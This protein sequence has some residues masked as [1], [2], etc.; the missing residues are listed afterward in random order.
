MHESMM[1]NQA[2]TL[3]QEE[4][5]QMATQGKW[6]RCQASSNPLTSS[7]YNL[8]R[9]ELH[10]CG[11]FETDKWKD[12][13]KATLKRNLRAIRVPTIM[14]LNPTCKH[15]DLNLDEYEMLDC[16]PMHDLKGHLFN[17]NKKLPYLLTRDVRKSCEDII[18]ATVSVK[19]TW[20]DRVLILQLYLHLR[21]EKSTKCILNPLETAIQ[22]LQILYLPAEERTHT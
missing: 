4:I 15:S 5:Q 16:E 2:H 11:N 22:I 12:V 10:A 7:E 9:E 21:Q 14:L 17:M 20:A 19:M 3:Q 8:L 1:D 13:L 6:E 18:V